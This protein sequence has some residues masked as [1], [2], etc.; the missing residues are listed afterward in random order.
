VLTSRR[1][2]RPGTTV[3]VG[4]GLVGALAAVASVWAL[5]QSRHG[6]DDFSG[7]GQG[8][9]PTRM[10]LVGNLI[11]AVAMIALTYLVLTQHRSRSDEYLADQVSDKPSPSGGAGSPID[12]EF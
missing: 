8:A 12:I 4:Y 6:T 5:I 9:G 7:F 1:R 10:I 2:H 3:V 11:A